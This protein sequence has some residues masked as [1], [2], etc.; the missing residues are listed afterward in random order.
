MWALRDRIGASEM[1]L[2]EQ[3]MEKNENGK[4]LD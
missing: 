1:Q 2:T 4:T 3:S